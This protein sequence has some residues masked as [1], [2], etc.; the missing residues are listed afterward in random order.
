[1][2]FG[3]FIFAVEGLCA[4]QGMKRDDALDAIARLAGPTIHANHAEQAALHDNEPQYTEVHAR[5]GPS[6]IDISQQGLEKSSRRSGEAPL[7]RRFSSRRGAKTCN[8]GRFSSGRSRRVRRSIFEKTKAEQ[9]RANLVLEELRQHL[10]QSTEQQLSAAF[11]E[12]ASFGSSAASLSDSLDG[13][14][15]IKWLTDSHVSFTLSQPNVSWIS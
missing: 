10:G 9:K 15:F 3:T 8:S 12:F 2:D 6:T 7:V 1:M 5:G 11:Q 4:R 14:N 13:R